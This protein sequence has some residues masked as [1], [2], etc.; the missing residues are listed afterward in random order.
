MLDPSPPHTVRNADARVCV[1]H[2]RRFLDTDTTAKMKVSAKNAE[3]IDWEGT[4]EVRGISDVATGFYLH[5]NL[6]GGFL[7]FT[8]VGGDIMEQAQPHDP[9]LEKF[10]RLLRR[11]PTQKGVNKSKLW[12]V[13][14]LIGLICSVVG[15]LL[16]FF[17]LTLRPSNYKLVEKSDHGVAICLGDK[18]VAS[19]FG[20]G[21]IVSDDRCPQE[22]GPS[23]APVIQAEKPTYVPWGLGLILVGFALQVP[24]ALNACFS[25]SRV[26]L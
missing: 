8:R 19:G 2:E 16:L 13:L 15:G 5:P 23:R 12:A 3:K 21:F 20:G 17:S 11:V 24:A 18:L 7:Q 4:L 14:N 1:T 9:A 26:R 22:S 6:A 10:Q 25:G